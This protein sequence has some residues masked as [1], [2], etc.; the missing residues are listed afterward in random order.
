MPL[1]SLQKQ[2]PLP[3]VVQFTDVFVK[4]RQRKNCTSLKGLPS[5]L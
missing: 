4:E 2:G 5:L 1:P 3:A